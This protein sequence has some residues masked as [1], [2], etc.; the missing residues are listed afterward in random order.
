[1]DIEELFSV[2]AAD[3]NCNTSYPLKRV[4]F[5]RYLLDADIMD[6][7]GELSLYYHIPFCRHLCR[8]CEYTRFLCDDVALQNDYVDKLIAQSEKFFEA[9]PVK[10]LYGLDI[11]GGTPTMLDISAFS[12]LLDYTSK[13]RRQSVL[14]DHFEPSIEFSFSAVDEKKINCIAEHRIP[15]MS[16]GIQVFDK[17]LMSDMRR[18]PQ[19]FEK[20]KNITDAIRS[21]GIPKLNIDLMYGFPNQTD[22]MLRNSIYAVANLRP[23]QVTLYELRY[24]RSDLLSSSVNRD[25]LFRQYEILYDGLTKLGYHGRFGRNTFTVT[26][27]EGVSSYLYHRMTAGLPY[28]GFG[29]SAQSMSRKGISYNIL[30]SCRDRMMPPFDE[31]REQDVY[32]LPKD[33]IAAKYVCISLYSGEFSPDVLKDILCC[34]PYEYYCEAFSFLSAKRYIDIVDGKCRLTRDG[35]RLYGAVAA[36]FWSP[37]HRD[38]YLEM[39]KEKKV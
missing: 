6:G 39:M 28:K 25:I 8:F 35:F 27:D 33:E 7:V 3:V 29:V 11:G 13:L 16:A 1:M 5:S 4:F 17:K 2:A 38:R 32:L 18:I 22:L 31:I 10:K 15:R 26:D 34:D 23:E 21:A 24:N 14:D 20:M 9:H 30:K 19:S 12:R 36:L 37:Y